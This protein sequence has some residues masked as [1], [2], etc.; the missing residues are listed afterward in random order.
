MKNTI[1]SKS[2]A[3]VIAI[4]VG[5]LFLLSVPFGIAGG[6]QVKMLI[7]SGVPGALLIY[8]G[9]RTKMTLSKFKEYAEY[10]SED[11]TGSID[12]LAAKTGETVE[13][14]RDNLQ[15]MIDKRYLVGAHIDDETNSIMLPDRE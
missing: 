4:I 7:I 10:L 2:M 3:A 14:V 6:M 8:M 15:R 9:I 1:S 13:E 5:A 11:P 12:K